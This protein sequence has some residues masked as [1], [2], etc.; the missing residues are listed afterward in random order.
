MTVIA[1]M[2]EEG[3]E[4]MAWLALRRGRLARTAA[5]LI[6]EAALYREESRG[7][8]HRGDFPSSIDRWRVSHV[9]W[10]KRGVAVVHNPAAHH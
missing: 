6:V 4:G 8:H 1:Q 9:M 7:A 2:G 3:E 10:K 5:R